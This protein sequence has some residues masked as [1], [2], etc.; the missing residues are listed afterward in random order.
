MFYYFENVDSTGVKEIVRSY[1]FLHPLR[2]IVYLT[3]ILLSHVVVSIKYL[4]IVPSYNKHGTYSCSRIKL[5]TKDNTSLTKS[6]F[7]Q[8][9]GNYS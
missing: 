5:K 4:F 6:S 8:L 3:S 9:T 1:L 2:A 7:L